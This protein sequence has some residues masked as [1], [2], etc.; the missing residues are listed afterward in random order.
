MMR[1]DLVASSIV[2]SVALAPAMAD[3]GGAT[4]A[5]VPGGPVTSSPGSS[6]TT[7]AAAG[8]VAVPSFGSTAAG[9]TYDSRFASAPST[10]LALEGVKP[11]LPGYAKAAGAAMGIAPNAPD[12]GRARFSFGSNGGSTIGQWLTDQNAIG[13]IHAC[14][15]THC[16]ST[17]DL[18]ITTVQY[19]RDPGYGYMVLCRVENTGGD[20]LVTIGDDDQQRDVA[21]L[22]VPAG[23]TSWVTHLFEPTMAATHWAAMRI[24][25]NSVTNGFF[26]YSLT[27]CEVQPYTVSRGG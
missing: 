24:R 15:A 2:I 5:S 1:R 3:G 20:L 26:R 23:K 7:G 21:T 8:G 4:G 19:Q 9:G 12:A 17:T 18:A 22:T 16:D 11:S 13:V 10:H 6:Q 25:T 14:A 27:R